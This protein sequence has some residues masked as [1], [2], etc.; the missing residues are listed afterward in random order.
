MRAFPEELETAALI[1]CLAEGWG[2]GVGAVEYAPLGGG[3]YHWVVSERDGTRGFVT[4]DDLDRKRWL[5]DTRESVFDG[6]R[7]AFDTT[8][9]LRDDGL[10]FVVAPIPA[11]SGQT[12]YRLGPRYSIALF[13][14]VDGDTGRFGQYEAAERIAI[15]TMLAQLHQATAAVDSVARRIDLDLPGRGDLEA[16]LLALVDPWS[17]GPF[18][19]PARQALARHASEVWEL[20][21]LADR[22]RAEVAKRSGAWVITHGEPHAANV[23]RTDRG[24]VLLDWDTAGLAPPERDLWMLVADTTAEPVIYTNATGRALESVA[25]DFFRLTW[26]LADLASFINVLRSPHRHNADTVKAHDG[27]MHCLTIRDRWVPLLD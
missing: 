26:D 2:F 5:G 8:V 15:E 23:M 10:D 24:H 27:V 7:R 6:L 11:D 25:L 21:A 18:A 12:V 22:L 4:V 19:E 1:D 13:P 17:A 3:S 14:F 16:A 20:L 9:A